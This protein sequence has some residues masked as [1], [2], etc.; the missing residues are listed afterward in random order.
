MKYFHFQ[1]VSDPVIFFTF[2]LWPFLFYDCVL[3]GNTRLLFDIFLLLNSVTS[4][5]TAYNLGVFEPTAK[6]AFM[7]TSLSTVQ[8]YGFHIFTVVYS[9]LHGYVW[10]QHDD[11]LPTA[12]EV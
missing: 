8:I 2:S 12:H 11:Q 1:L 7:L 9:P 5:V 6:I 3:A 4:A 10:N